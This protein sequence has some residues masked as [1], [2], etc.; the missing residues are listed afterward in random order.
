MCIRDS[1]YTSKTNSFWGTIISGLLWGLAALNRPVFL[2]LP[3]FM[4]ISQLLLQLF[5]K[6]IQW[7]WRIK[8]WAIGILVMIITISPWT[9]HNLF[10]HEEFVPIHTAS[11][12]MMLICNGKL[13]HPDIQKGLFYYKDEQYKATLNDNLTE[14]EKDKL[15]MKMALSEIRSNWS[16]L[17]KPILNRAK[18]FW[19]WRPDPYDNN[20]TRNDLVMALVYICLLYTSDAADE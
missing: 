12:Y 19:T 3:V 4:L 18:N 6:H 14:I 1:L 13:N 5:F 8:N 9:I 20:F 7:K 10:V 15:S 11:G 17:P 2:M 16:L